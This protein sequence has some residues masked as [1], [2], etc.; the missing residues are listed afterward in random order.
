[1]SNDNE[2][3]APASN[4]NLRRVGALALLSAA[5]TLIAVG[6]RVG[7]D[8]D[9]PTLAESLNAIAENRLEYSLAW[10]V[11][12]VSGVALSAAALL[13][14]KRAPSGEGSGLRPILAMFAVSGL[15][16]VFSSVCSALLTV[17]APAAEPGT[18]HEAVEVQ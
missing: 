6:A 9:Q 2:I 8:A 16:T 18:S 15:F 5:A 13:A 4:I 17:M 11:R 10:M 7:A 1:M 14:W 12:I 3:A